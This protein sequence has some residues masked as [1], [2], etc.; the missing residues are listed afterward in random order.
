MK[1]GRLDENRKEERKNQG[2]NRKEREKGKQGKSKTRWKIVIKMSNNLVYPK[3]RLAV[4]VELFLDILLGPSNCWS[5]G[6]H[7]LGSIYRVS[8]LKG[9]DQDRG[10]MSP[11]CH[12]QER[13]VLPKLM[14]WYE[15]NMAVKG[16]K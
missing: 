11:Q 1:G 8:L 9:I 7:C 5:H 13:D 10:I 12:Y 6:P 4:F 16:P 3:C 14:K 2:P 15:E